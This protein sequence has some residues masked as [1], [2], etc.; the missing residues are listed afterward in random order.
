MC[1]KEDKLVK[2]VQRRNILIKLDGRSP[3]G[4]ATALEYLSDD[5]ASD[6]ENEKRM[7]AAETRALVKKKRAKQQLAV[8]LNKTTTYR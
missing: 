7:R 1:K 8:T 6:S 4:W 5:M 3:A 2:E